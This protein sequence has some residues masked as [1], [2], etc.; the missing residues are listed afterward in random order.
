[1]GKVVSTRSRS[2]ARPLTNDRRRVCLAA[3]RH[4]LG[5]H[6]MIV[7]QYTVLVILGICDAMEA[8]YDSVSPLP[9]SFLLPAQEPCIL[10]PLAVCLGLLELLVGRPLGLVGRALCSALLHDKFLIEDETDK[11]DDDESDVAPQQREDHPDHRAG[12]VE[13]AEEGM[14]EGGKDVED[15]LEEVGYGRG[16]GHGC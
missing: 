15:R 2:K 16:N 10:L 1:V 11:D 12:P 7:V 14:E 9:P 6:A 8:G 4:A 5:Q 3:I 13:H